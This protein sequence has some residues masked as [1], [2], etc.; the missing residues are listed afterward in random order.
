MGKYV[1]ILVVVTTFI[2]NSCSNRQPQTSKTNLSATE[3]S[4]KI[5]ELP[6]VPVIDVR[7]PEE[8]SNGHLQNA[9]NIDWKRNNFQN[10]I[11]KLD[12]SKPVFVYCLSGGRSSSAARKMRLDG[13]K[14]VYELNGGINKWRDANLLETTDNKSIINKNE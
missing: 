11:S 4:E 10:K 7:T 5:K 2:F 6:S 9:Q 13:F 12:K 1:S 14:E 3:F 8:Y